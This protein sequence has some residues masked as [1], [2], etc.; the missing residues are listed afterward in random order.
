[1]PAFAMTA[2]KAQGQTMNS[3]IVDLE[4]CVGTES[5]YVMVSRVKSLDGSRIL[6]P[7]NITKIQCHQ[8]EDSRK[9]FRR[10]ELLHLLT[11]VE[12]GTTS[13]RAEAQDALSKTNYRDQTGPE[14]KDGTY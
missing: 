2:H 14:N 8:S 4:S 11:I 7:F 5:P 1:M 13:E 6:R 10:L 12:F 3:V 9:E